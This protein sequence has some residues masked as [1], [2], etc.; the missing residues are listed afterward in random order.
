MTT[1][2]I[3]LSVLLTTAAAG[4]HAD[5]TVNTT[6]SG[7]A[8]FINVGGD[9]VTQIKG[10]RQRSDNMMGGKTQSLIIDIDGRRF[11][12]LD[13]KG[14]KA[15]V[16]PLESIADELQKVGIGTMNATLT[17]TAQTKQVA[18]Y[19][20]TEG[21]QHPIDYRTQDFKA[22]VRRLTDGEGVDVVMDAMGPT[23]FRKIR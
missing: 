5:V 22:E 12:D 19:P 23:S 1:S 21:V 17:K 3:L 20:C 8:S 15:T 9:G 2:K 6:T 10:A 11:V 18:S 14:K 13:A 4:A 16:T 7:K